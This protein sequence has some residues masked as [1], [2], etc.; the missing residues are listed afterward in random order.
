MGMAISASNVAFS[1][2]STEFEVRVTLYI[3]TY[4]YDCIS[5]HATESMYVFSTV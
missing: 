1:S 4:N 2:N 5:S 3:Q